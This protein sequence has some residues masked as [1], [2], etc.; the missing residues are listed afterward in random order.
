MVKAKL[1]WYGTDVMLKIEKA[2]A[3]MV[4][5]IAFVLEGQ[6]KI[7]AKVD[8]GFMRNATYAVPADESPSD[9]GWESGDYDDRE[10]NTVFR[11]RSDSVP[12]LRKHQAAVHFAAEYTI[13][14]E[15]REPFIYPALE[16]TKDILSTQGEN[17]YI[18]KRRK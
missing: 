3:E 13:H 12:S 18:V 15:M 10:G 14:V 6:A 5:K 4:T 2:S 17:T 7:G 1:N 11:G 9:T 8:T 16:A